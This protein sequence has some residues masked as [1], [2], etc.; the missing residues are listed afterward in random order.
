MIDAYC[1]WRRGRCTTSRLLVGVAGEKNTD[2]I[3]RDRDTGGRA[4]LKTLGH[5]GDNQPTRDFV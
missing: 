3:Y 5:M 4:S 2:V 1:S